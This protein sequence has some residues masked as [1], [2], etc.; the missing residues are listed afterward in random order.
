MDVNEDNLPPSLVE[1]ATLY[2]QENENKEEP[3]YITN[4]LE[5]L[6]DTQ[7]QC[8]IIEKVSRGQGDTTDWHE[9]RKGRITASVFHNV[10]TKVQTIIAGRKRVI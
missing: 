4:F 5:S 9:Q 3:E 1:A 7:E 2:A 8:D 10:H 6:H